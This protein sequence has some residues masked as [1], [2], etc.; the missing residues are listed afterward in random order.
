MLERA[1]LIYIRKDMKLPVEQK[2]IN[3][4]GRRREQWV[5]VEFKEIVRG[6]VWGANCHDDRIWGDREIL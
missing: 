6:K 3:L 1:K 4:E 2:T 5:G